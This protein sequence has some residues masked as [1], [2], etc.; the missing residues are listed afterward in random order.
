MINT[1]RS[2]LSPLCVALLA[3]SLSAQHTP[4]PDG[5]G[6]LS[7]PE[8]S[9]GGGQLRIFGVDAVP[10]GAATLT[11]AAL[12]G[13]KLALKLDNLGSSGCD[14]VSVA[15]NGG[16]VAALGLELQPTSQTIPSESLWMEFSG[17][18]GAGQPGLLGGASWQLQS[19]PVLGDLWAL[20]FDS[21]ALGATSHTLH[22]L[23]EGWLGLSTP[24]AD[25]DALVLEA[26]PYAVSYGV[27]RDNPTIYP[28]FVVQMNPPLK[29]VGIQH[30][31]GGFTNI[32][33]TVSRVRAVPDVATP[34]TV[35]ISAVQLRCMDV[36]ELLVSQVSQSFQGASLAGTDQALIT[37]QAGQLVVDNLGSSGCDGVSI[38]LGDGDG[39]GT[40]MAGGVLEIAPPS[41]SG[42]TPVGA[43]FRVTLDATVQGEQHLGFASIMARKAPQGSLDNI[44]FSCDPHTVSLDW[45]YELRLAGQVVATG[46]PSTVQLFEVA[47]AFD[48]FTEV[49]Y[50]SGPDTVTDMPGS[51]IALRSTGAPGLAMVDGVSHTFDELRL[52]IAASDSWRVTAIDTVTLQSASLG[53]ITIL[54]VDDKPTP[55]VNLGQLHKHRGHVTVLKGPL[56]GGGSTEAGAMSSVMLDDAPVNQPGLLF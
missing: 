17:V 13:G 50:G 52:V 15:P 26:A 48:R 19:D 44:F 21:L 34:S 53:N 37:Q 12:P 4:I 56:A 51:G 32:D 22:L 14:G 9:L 36:T 47:K 23:D 40:F 35:T 39:S 8:L 27:H 28:D 3:A 49:L 30:Q 1:L 55:A 2:A 11:T 25:G 54:Q 6:Q 41:S 18:V 10:V 20:S 5:V 31:G 7:A 38:D 45:R 29:A 33:L 46:D 43:T 16:P 42:T 24:L